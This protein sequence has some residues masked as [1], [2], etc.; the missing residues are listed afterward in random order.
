MQFGEAGID[1]FNQIEAL[2]SSMTTGIANVNYRGSNA[3]EFKNK[4]A[5]H[6]V[7]F[8]NSCTTTMQS[9]S[10]VITDATSFIAVNLG[11]SAIN[12]DPPKVNVEMPSIDADTS[13][14]SA[15]SGP[16][17]ALRDSVDASCSKIGDLFNENLTNLQALGRDGW[18]G[19]EYDD[20][21]QQVSSLTTSIVEDVTKARST[22]TGD[23][24]SQLEALGM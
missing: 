3:L 21:L 10:S 17:V 13:V 24:S 7:E 9:I 19:P 20:A 4:C 2:L 14:E 15:E 11:G 22:I 12:L 5:S 18:I 23:I 6:A 16:L 8:G 1:I